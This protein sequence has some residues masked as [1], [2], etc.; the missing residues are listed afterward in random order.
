MTDQL[1]NQLHQQWQGTDDEARREAYRGRAYWLAT[2]VPRSELAFSGLVALCS[3]AV[4]IALWGHGAGT[5]LGLGAGTLAV[6]AVSAAPSIWTL[7]HPDLAGHHL[8]ASRS[9]SRTRWRKHPVAVTFGVVAFAFVDGFVRVSDDG[10]GGRFAAGAAAAGSAL[11]VCAFLL[12]HY[13]RH[14]PSSN[15]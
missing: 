2:P 14:M 13:R 7:R 5:A 8:A 10:T 4:V 1:S 15:H 9:Y 12:W 6:A 11:I 3:I